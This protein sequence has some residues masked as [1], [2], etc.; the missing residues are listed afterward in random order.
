MHRELKGYEKDKKK[1]FVFDVHV[2]N[3]VIETIEVGKGQDLTK[4]IE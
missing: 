1:G 4:L 3:G 2:G